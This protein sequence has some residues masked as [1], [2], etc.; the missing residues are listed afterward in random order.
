MKWQVG[1][2]VAVEQQETKRKPKAYVCNNTAEW[3]FESLDDAME[4]RELR[5]TGWKGNA[6][7]YYKWKEEE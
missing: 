2:K 1:E 3:D 5:L 6:L 7:D 4:F